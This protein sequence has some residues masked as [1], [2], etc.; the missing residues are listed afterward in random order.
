MIDYALQHR[1]CDPHWTQPEY[2]PGGARD[3]LRLETLS[4]SIL[5]HAFRGEIVPQYPDDEPAP[6]LLERIREERKARSHQQRWPG[7]SKRKILE[8]EQPRPF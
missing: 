3:A 6:V 1:K 4:E 8:A 5:A 2:K 7:E